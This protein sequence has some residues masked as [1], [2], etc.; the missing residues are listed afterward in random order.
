MSSVT[1]RSARVAANVFETFRSETSGAR[2]STA[3]GVDV[4]E[5]G[6]RFG[7]HDRTGPE[8]HARQPDDAG[9]WLTPHSAW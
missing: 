6:N 7:E 4:E 1:P 8:A 9:Y 5:P 3:S 2:C